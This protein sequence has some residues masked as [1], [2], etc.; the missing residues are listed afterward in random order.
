[1]S[2]LNAAIIERKSFPMSFAFSAHE[3]RRANKKSC[4]ARGCY[5]GILPSQQPIKSLVLSLPYNN[6]NSVQYCAGE[7]LVRN[8]LWDWMAL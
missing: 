2:H 6:I 3:K 5:K 7:E 8:E 4:N 1:M